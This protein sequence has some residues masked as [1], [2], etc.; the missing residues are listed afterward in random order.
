M[1]LKQLNLVI[2]NFFFQR[3]KRVHRH[4]FGVFLLCW[5]CGIVV[6]FDELFGS[7]GKL[8]VKKYFCLDSMY[9]WKSFKISI[10]KFN[11]V[12]CAVTCFPKN[13][14]VCQTVLFVTPLFQGICY[15]DG[16]AGWT[17]EGCPV[18]SHTLYVWRYVPFKGVVHFQLLHIFF[19]KESCLPKKERK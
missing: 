3:D 6:N 9:F 12:S 18:Q 2:Y 1:T 16:M 4:S 5:P 14:S 19:H 7:E 11:W 13:F 10:V 8:Q 17:F 15:L